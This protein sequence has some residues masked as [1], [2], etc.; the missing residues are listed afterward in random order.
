[1]ILKKSQLFIEF[2]FIWFQNL[3]F[4]S[5]RKA[6]FYLKYFC[7]HPFFRQSFFA[8]WGGRNTLPHPPV[9]STHVWPFVLAL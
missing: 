9:T 7:F 4:C 5:A 3:K 1:M 6:V 2:A 8:A